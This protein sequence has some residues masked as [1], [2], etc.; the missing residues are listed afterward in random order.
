MKQ[1]YIFP[2]YLK[3]ISCIVNIALSNSIRD[4]EISRA[5]FFTGWGLK[6]TSGACI[7]VALR[8]C[9]IL[10]YN[11]FDFFELGLN[12]RKKLQTYMC[13]CVYILCFALVTFAFIV[14]RKRISFI[15]LKP[16]FRQVIVNR[17]TLPSKETSQSSF[18]VCTY[19]CCC[20]MSIQVSL[21]RLD[22]WSSSYSSETLPN[23]SRHEQSNIIF[24][25][26][27]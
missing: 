14:L 26:S 6:A 12:S 7:K 21:S 10:Y 2:L 13:V 20:R 17:I 8:G 18:C 4:N 15:F 23:P 27:V 5:I 9:D 24:I 11:T 22:Q 19:V 16:L 3:K 1:Y 25:I